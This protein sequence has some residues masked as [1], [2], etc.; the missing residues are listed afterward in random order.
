[1]SAPPSTFG[2]LIRY[3]LVGLAVNAAGYAVYL[4]ATWLGAG[5]K[6]TM[7][8]LYVA[9]VFTGYVGHRRWAF[10]YRGA[11]GASL[12]RYLICHAGGY[13]LNFFLLFWFSDR[14]GYPHQWVQ[15]VAILV[16][17]LFL[18]LAFRYVAFAPRR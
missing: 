16:V 4:L 9:G 7:S 8:V 15:A 11:I 6:S 3:G 12:A 13:A 10:A 17:A 1:M 18:F 2:S 5:P 14:L